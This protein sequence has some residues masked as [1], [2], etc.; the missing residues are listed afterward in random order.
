VPYIDA[1]NSSTECLNGSLVPEG[2]PTY[3]QSEYQRTGQQDYCERSLSEKRGQGVT[4]ITPS[5][6][7]HVDIASEITPMRSVRSGTG[8]MDVGLRAMD[9]LTSSSLAQKSER[10]NIDI[11]LVSPY[12]VD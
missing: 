8:S 12:N 1:N 7:I 5:P 11:N 6:G 2:P 4:P 10:G 9:Y 3:Q